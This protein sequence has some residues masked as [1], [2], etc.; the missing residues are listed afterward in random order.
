MELVNLIKD[1]YFGLILTIFIFFLSTKLLKK[2][3]IPFLNPLILSIILIIIILLITGIK[4]ED[5]YNGGNLLNLLITPATVVLA[6]PLY[7]SFELFKKNFKIILIS[8]T[9]TSIIICVLLVLMGHILGL[10][11]ELIASILPKSIT[12]AIGVEVSKQLGGNL[13]LTIITII[14]T[15]NIGMIIADYVFKIFKI[16]TPLARGIALGTSAHAIGTVKAMELGEIEG[17]MSGVAM[18][19]TGVLVVFIA[20][21]VFY[22]YTLIIGVI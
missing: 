19:I 18:C 1:P 8:I 7:N 3:K 16:N 10:N 20:P 12:T 11:L 14:L 5:Y 15:G 4:Y 22:I 17:A 21:L 6:V 13:S 2:I 9:I